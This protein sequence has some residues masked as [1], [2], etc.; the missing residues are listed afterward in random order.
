MKQVQSLQKSVKAVRKCVLKHR[1]QL[2]ASAKHLDDCGVKMLPVFEDSSA[3]AQ[4]SLACGL[5]AARA[6]GMLDPSDQRSKQPR[7][8]TIGA[9]E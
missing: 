2:L 1:D 5:T 9:H 6:I 7:G 3:I 8:H 4:A